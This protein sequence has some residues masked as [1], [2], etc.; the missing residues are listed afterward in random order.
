MGEIKANGG[1][2]WQFTPKKDVCLSTIST[3]NP[4]AGVISRRFLNGAI[5]P[6]VMRDILPQGKEGNPENRNIQVS[7]GKDII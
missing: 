5:H 4:L 2:P 1:C 3:M 7:G 6:A